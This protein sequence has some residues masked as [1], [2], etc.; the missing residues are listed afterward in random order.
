MIDRRQFLM[1]ALGGV[2]V[3]QQ[4]KLNDTLSLLTNVGTN[5]LALSTSDGLIL[6]DSGAPKYGNAL[7]KAVK[8]VFTKR[9]S[10]DAVLQDHS[11]IGANKEATAA[12]RN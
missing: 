2:V 1:G 10:P 5:V 11:D 7:P 3:F 8:T 9:F 6:V 4:S 12:G